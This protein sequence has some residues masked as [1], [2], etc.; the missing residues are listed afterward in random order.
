MHGPLPPSVEWFRTMHGPPPSL[1]WFRTM[2][3]P[4]PQL[5]N[6]LEPPMDDEGSQPAYSVTRPGK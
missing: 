6:G 1:E 4:P 2:H 5:W 3:G